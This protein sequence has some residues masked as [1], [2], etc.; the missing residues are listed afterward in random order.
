MARTAQHRR[1]GGERGRAGLWGGTC[2]SQGVQ[3]LVVRRQSMKRARYGEMF[4]IIGY[5]VGSA[6]G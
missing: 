6:R 1:R 4:V 5:Y 3:G 2:T